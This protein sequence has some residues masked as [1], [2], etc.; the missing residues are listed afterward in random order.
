MNL[1]GKTALVTGS[2]SGIGLGIALK[3]AEAGA[4]LV[5]N[6]FGDVEAAVQAVSAHGGQV[7][8][9]PAD[10]SKPEEIEALMQFCEAQFGSLDI[11]VNN[12]G[13]QHVAPVEEFP[14]ERWNAVIAINLSSA[15]HTTRLA[16]PG[17]RERNWGR[18]INIA[19]AH[20]LAASAGKS[21][22]VAAKHG[23]VGLTKSVA[24]ETATTGITCNAICPGW[25]LTPLV[26]KQIDSRAVDG[27]IARS[28]HDLLAEKQP[29]LDF[30]TPEQLGELALFLCSDAAIQVRGA[31]WNM[32]GGWLAQ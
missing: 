17:M 30:V 6:G 29:S 31:A 13:I 7:R 22:Y 15:F 16:L 1:H 23:L 28:R 14:V 11:L 19:S 26:Q 4:N 2:T 8:H 20:G 25:V 3:L 5:L 9:H 27:D 24:L 12:A 21:A 18:I 10:M 32:D